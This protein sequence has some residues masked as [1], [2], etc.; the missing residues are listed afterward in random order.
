MREKLLQGPFIERMDDL[1]IDLHAWHNSKFP[2]MELGVGHGETSFA[3]DAV[4]EEEYIEVDDPGAVPDAPLPSHRRLCSV[5]KVQQSKCRVI[6]VDGQGTIHKVF[7]NHFGNRGGEVHG[8]G[9]P[10][11]CSV[12]GRDGPDAVN[13]VPDLVADIGSDAYK[14]LAVHGALSGRFILVGIFLR[15][16]VLLFVRFLGCL[17]EAFN[18]LADRAADFGEFACTKDHYD[19]DKDNNKFWKSK[20][21]HN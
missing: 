5:E 19:N 17:F 9:V 8:G 21:K 2:F 10:H 20:A 6:P 12:V 3:D 4:A 18:A 14:D 16:R 15:R 1:P 7:L 13:T 11:V